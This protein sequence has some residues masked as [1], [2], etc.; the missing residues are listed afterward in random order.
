MKEVIEN[1]KYLQQMWNNLAYLWN[2]GSTYYHRQEDI[3]IDEILGV[4]TGYR[5]YSYQH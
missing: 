2:D 1:I 3:D 5:S 4:H